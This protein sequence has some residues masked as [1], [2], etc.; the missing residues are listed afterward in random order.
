MS[1]EQQ[2]L[3][4]PT[5]TS[6]QPRSPR[7]WPLWALS[8]LTLLLVLALGAAG[9]FFWQTQQQVGSENQNLSQRL[10]ALEQQAGQ[11]GNNLDQRLQHLRQMLDKQN[12]TLTRHSREIDHNAQALLSAGHRSH[13][14]W[15][16]AEAEYLL[17]IANQRLQVEQ[18]FRGAL[19]LLQQADQ[20]LSRTDDPGVFPVRKALAQ[21]EM[22]L[23]RVQGVDRTGLYLKLEAALDNVRNIDQSALIQPDRP[24]QQTKARPEAQDGDGAQPSAWQKIVQSLKN[25]IIIRRLDRPVKPLPTPEQSAY[26]QLDLRMRLQQAEIALLRGNARIYQT[27]LRQALDELDQWFDSSQPPVAAL[28]STLQALAGRDINP[29]LPDISQSLQLLK[30]R[31]AGRDQQAGSGTTTSAPASSTSAPAAGGQGEVSQ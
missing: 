27:A 25:V 7:L 19:K 24:A 3:P 31:I 10:S 26:L 18:D 14:D 30:A 21:E 23:K 5:P 1:E 28:K 2:S 8:G 11:R 17:R 16:L 13:T 29:E 12:D 4:V 9:W 6:E 15:L 20:V 22:A